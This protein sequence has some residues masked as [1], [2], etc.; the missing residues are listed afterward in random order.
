M[1]GVLWFIVYNLN[2]FWGS[3]NGIVLGGG[4][5]FSFNSYKYTGAGGFGL[6]G[7]A[8]VE[9]FYNIDMPFTWDIENV[10]DI[11]VFFEW[12]VGDQALRWY[13]VNSQPKPPSQDNSGCGSCP[14]PQTAAPQ[15]QMQY[16]AATSV[17]QLCQNMAQAGFSGNIQSVSVINPP[18]VPTPGPQPPATCTQV[19]F[20]NVSSCQQFA[21]QSGPVVSMVMNVFANT[22]VFQAIG[23]GGMTLA[24]GAL[25]TSSIFPPIITYTGSGGM[26]LG[27]S[28]SAEFTFVHIPVNKTICFADM[29]LGGSAIIIG[30][31]YNF[32]Y[33][34]SGGIGMGG[35]AMLPIV[36]SGGITLGGF[37]SFVSPSWHYTGTGGFGVTGVYA[38]VGSGGMVLAGTGIIGNVLSFIGGGSIILGGGGSFVSPS[39][40]YA[41]S[42]GMSLAGSGLCRSNFYNP[43]IPMVMTASVTFVEADFTVEQGTTLVAPLDTVSTQCGCNS[44]PLTLLFQSNFGSTNI[45]A[46]FLRRNGLTLP[47]SQPLFYNRLF[48]MWQQNLHITGLAEDGRTTERW[49][50]LFEWGCSNQL[51][52]QD[53]GQNFW[54]FQGNFVRR[55]AVIGQ[56]NSRVMVIMDSSGLCADPGSFGVSFTIDTVS[57]IVT[58]QSQASLELQVIYDEIGLF[59]GTWTASPVLSITLALVPQTLPFTFVDGTPLL[60]KTPSIFV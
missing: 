37:G 40:H 21:L 30:Q 44:L 9:L 58:I 38:Y 56:Q 18:I 36:G 48:G 5:L 52:D 24:G 6:C 12:T 22:N 43:V 20:K 7:S 45:F 1:L 19:P 10:I 46:T 33:V 11:E 47:T 34:G 26:T 23:I 14:N 41:G 53:T 15:C 17:S 25:F 42:G 49:D 39:W 27:G 54:R 55:N 3:P 32:S 4:A 50:V 13:Q 8:D 51:A 2:Q 57:E 16:F 28:G 29:A 31:N 59:R 60:L 35:Q